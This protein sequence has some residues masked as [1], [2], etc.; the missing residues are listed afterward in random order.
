MTPTTGPPG[1]VLVI[2]C[3]LIGTSIGLALR[4]RGVDVHLVDRDPEVVRTAAERGAG[5]P[6][7]PSGPPSVVV[8]AVPPDLV[9]PVVVESL[10]TWPQAVVTDVGSVKTAPLEAVARATSDFSRYV[11]G[12]P[13]AGSE[14]SG[15]LA[16]SADLFDGRVWAVTPHEGC[17]RESVAAVCGLALACG[18]ETARLTPTEHDEAVALVSHVP[19]VMAVLAASRLD[20]APGDHLRLSGQ[21]IRDVTRIAA[22]DPALWQQ[23]LAANAGA[24][25]P[26]LSGVRADLDRFIGELSSSA[27]RVERLL[28]R[29]V[30]GTAAIP[31]KHGGPPRSVDAVFVLVPDRPGEL[32]RLFADTGAGG[33]NIEDIRIDH[34]LGRPSGLVELSVPQGDGD[35][36][37]AA[38]ADRGWSVHR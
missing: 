21:G 18:A 35:R 6:A 32:G 29:G 33:V 16:A 1:P 31:G 17:S 3:G 34:A 36:L 23:I 13:M 19:H 24:V 30:S 20:G 11:G 7:P 4:G 14:R 15:P 27:P 2:G 10:R 5:D 22:G 38:L 12:H 25:V 37:V 26:L 28:E 8:V 9:G